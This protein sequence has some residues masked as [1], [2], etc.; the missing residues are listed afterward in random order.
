M[1]QG[2][3][4]ESRCNQYK[5]TVF[6]NQDV[7]SAAFADENHQADTANDRSTNLSTKDCMN[8][9]P[10]IDSFINAEFLQDDDPRYNCR[11][12]VLNAHFGNCLIRTFATTSHVDSHHSFFRDT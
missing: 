12:K 4:R 2:C 10:G 7:G 1:A 11:Q 3:T 8:V 6:G 5:L 9:D